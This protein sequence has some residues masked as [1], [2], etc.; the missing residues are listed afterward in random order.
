L[1]ETNEFHVFLQNIDW[2]NYGKKRFL[3]GREK[4]AFCEIA[5]P[6]SKEDAEQALREYKRF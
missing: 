4:I 2:E 6:L 5:I 1:V 3:M